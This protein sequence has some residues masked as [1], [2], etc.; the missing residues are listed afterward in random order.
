[1]DDNVFYRLAPFIREYIYR[2]NWT[3][4][5]AIQVE[6]CRV[7]FESDDHLLLSSGT[8]SGKTE[9]A[10]LPVL[11]E[12]MNDR[13][14]SVGVLYIAPIKALINDQFYRLNDL[15]KESGIPVWHWHGDVAA[16]SK[17][18]VLANPSGILQ[19]TPESLEGM[20]INRNRDLLR[21]FGDLRYIIIDEI[22]AF[23]GTDRGIQVQCQLER[24]ER[25]TRKPPRR[26]GLSATLGDYTLAEQWLASGTER[27]VQTPVVK[28]GS[29][30]LR[31]LVEHFYETAD[32]KEEKGQD[33]DEAAETAIASDQITQAADEK[34]TENTSTNK[35]TPEKT[36]SPLASE[37]FEFIY[38]KSLG[39]K[40]II[41][42]NM[43]NDAEY[44]I[45]TLRQMAKLRGAP[46]VYYVHHGSISASLREA[47][48]TAMKEDPGPVVVG[49]TTTLELGIDI[50]RLETAIQI[51]AP[52]SVSSFLQ[53]LGRTGRRGGASEMQFVSREEKP[54]GLTPLPQQIPWQMLQII[55]II[56]LYLKQRWIEPAV[57]Q[58]YPLSMLYH[59]TMSVLS[60]LGEMSPSGLASR[61]LGLKPFS[62]IT[63]DDYRLL[64]NHLI[65]I[66]HIQLTDEKSLI[67]GLKGEKITGNYKFFA[68]FPE[69]EEYIVTAESK[70]IGKV[71]VPPPPGERMTLAG[72]TWEVT[73]VDMKQKIVTVREI[74]GKIRT[75]WYGAGMRINNRI[76]EYMQGIL[77]SDEVY[78]YLGSHAKERL[79]ELRFLAANTGMIEHNVISMGGKTSCIFPWMGSTDYHVLMFL[80]KRFCGR[81]LD[82]KSIGG[83][84]PYYIVIRTGK[85][86]TKDLLN[87]IKGIFEMNFDLNS[88]LSDEDVADLKAH[89]QSKQPKFDEFIPLALHKKALLA[90]VIDLERLKNAV[91]GWS[92]PDM[93]SE[94]A[95]PEHEYL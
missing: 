19:I 70:Q 93:E 75:F 86:N 49:A 58:K 18:K 78:P 45:A 7:I 23:M 92:C 73:E 21:L 83:L 76:P 22:H 53:R 85:G 30:K 35:E 48:E 56:E 4:L 61:V 42:T 62:E 2:N 95:R 60:G 88:I 47:A 33:K 81:V 13:P 72:R 34:Q 69:E 84:A 46:D 39:K 31:L 38:H 52:H 77:K 20:L 1:M 17:R 16:S 11:T 36:D 59:Q 25:F 90:D 5:R 14:A 55:A 94:I 54:S 8:A 79:D 51:N 37:Y 63:F 10:F 9:A 27:K 57:I 82:I 26:I 3:E 15:L 64:L 74:N 43:R 68:V 28:T 32:A 50:G 24:L 80:I 12:I 67:V 29:Q 87:L 91:M 6:A 66:G 44:T 65:E 41:F 40:C 71:E 89:I